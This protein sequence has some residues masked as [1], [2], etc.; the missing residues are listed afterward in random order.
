MAWSFRARSKEEMMEWWNDIRMLCAR[1]LIASE[2]I[3]RNGPVEAAVRAAGYQSEEEE[4]E[5]D[6]S[7][8]EEEV[9]EGYHEAVEAPAPLEYSYEKGYQ[10]AELGPHGYAVKP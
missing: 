10:G 8:V 4:G 5:F 9:D 1:Y 2:Q 6:G 3:E 7:S